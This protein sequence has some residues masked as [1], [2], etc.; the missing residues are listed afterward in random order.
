MGHRSMYLFNN[1]II[2]IV[3]GPGEGPGGPGPPPPPKSQ[4]LDGRSPPLPSPPPLLFEGLYPSNVN[5]Y[6]SGWGTMEFPRGKL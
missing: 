2:Y 3:A 4:G 6:L 1:V 5:L